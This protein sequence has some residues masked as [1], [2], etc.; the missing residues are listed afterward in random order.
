MMMSTRKPDTFSDVVQGCIYWKLTKHQVRKDIY[1]FK[2]FL[3]TLSTKSGCKHLCKFMTNMLWLYYLIHQITT[4]TAV[5][6]VLG[7]LWANCDVLLNGV[8]LSRS[9]AGGKTDLV[10]NHFSTSIYIL[11]PLGERHFIL[12][13]V[14]FCTKIITAV[15]ALTPFFVFIFVYD[16]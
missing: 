12:T 6:S 13:A 8:R 1:S 3:W 10:E 15:C 7:V 4:L 2:C 5:W 11:P 16:K 14:S 9:G